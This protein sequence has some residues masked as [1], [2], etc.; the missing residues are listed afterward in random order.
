MSCHLAIRSWLIDRAFMRTNQDLQS[1]PT[2]PLHRLALGVS[3]RGQ[4]YQGWQSQLSGATVQD[5]LEAALSQF[6]NTPVRTVCAGRTD[7]G[8]H[9]VQQVVHLETNLHRAASSW[10]R[11]TNRY[12]PADVA[13][14]WCQPVEPHFHARFSAI[15]R[16]YRYVLLESPVRP[17]LDAGLVGWYFK[18]L[19]GDAMQ[20]AA[21]HL[22]G[23]HDF[24]AF[25][26]AQCQARSPV[27]TLA[28]LRIQRQGRCWLFDFDA[29]AFLHHMVRN[30]VGCLIAVGCGAQAAD[31]LLEV[32]LSRSRQKAAPTFAADGLYFVGPYYEPEHC[33]PEPEMLWAGQQVR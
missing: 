31:W 33:I 32:L 12:L 4:R 26:A 14:Q 16:R 28:S 13:V 2:L 9:A 19:N 29:N 8:V 22:L 11:G 1:G 25:R 24:S 27:K 23:T 21:A 18:P 3:Y 15:G 6:L 20:Q 7:A 30:I 10:V 5:H 17:S